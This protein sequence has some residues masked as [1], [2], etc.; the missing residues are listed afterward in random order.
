M[1]TIFGDCLQIMSGLKDNSV[2]MVLCDLPYRQTKLSWDTE[3]DL[4]ELWKQ[5]DRITK[6]NSAILLFGQEPFSSSLRLSNVKNYKYDWY[7]EKER[8]TNVFQVKKRAG[9][10]IETIS[11]FYKKQPTYNPQMLIHTGKPVTNSPKGNHTGTSATN[12]IK[13]TPYVDN[14]TRYPTQVLKF[15]RDKS[16][17][18]ETQK[19]LALCEFLINTYT[20][21]GDVVL[22]NCA[23]S[24]T[25][26][27]A[28]KN[29]GRDCIL[30]E[31]DKHYFD[32]LTERLR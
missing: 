5:Y 24:G 28:C 30:I 26:G 3:I 7:W 18:H 23:G 19:P 12:L 15:N 4:K 11:V 6:E 25:T 27:L 10:T 22:D 9:K 16:K 21:H 8:L 29:T 32:V 31:N 20:N 14:G 17:L 13:V 1:T 2:N